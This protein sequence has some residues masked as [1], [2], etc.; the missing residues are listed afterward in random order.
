MNVR[1]KL[2][3]VG[4]SLESQAP[5][6]LVTLCVTGSVLTHVTVEPTGTVM[7]GGLKVKPT[8]VITKV[9]GGFVTITVSASDIVSEPEVP[10]TCSV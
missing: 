9:L 7:V 10:T 4:K 1:V 5:V 6:E 2:W 8:G 3:P